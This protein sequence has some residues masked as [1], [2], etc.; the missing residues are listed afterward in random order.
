MRCDTC[1]A[2]CSGTRGSVS[3]AADRGAAC[4]G[5]IRR[6]SPGLVLGGDPDAGARY[7]GGFISFIGGR[8]PIVEVIAAMP[9]QNCPEQ[10]DRFMW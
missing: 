5:G 9:G 2:G 1:E 8:G 10:P 4:C 3:G 6:S 7:F